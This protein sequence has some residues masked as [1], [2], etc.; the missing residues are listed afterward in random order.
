MRRFVRFAAASLVLATSVM[1]GV[2][3]GPTPEPAR[4]A[5]IGVANPDTLTMKH[6]R[7]AVVPAPGVL[8]NDLNLLGGATA[9]LVSGVTHGTLSLRSD[10]GYTYSP[11]AGYVGSDLFR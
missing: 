3:I 9:I 10:G 1:S 2:V 4:A 11:A 7:T 8:G 5:L 6:D